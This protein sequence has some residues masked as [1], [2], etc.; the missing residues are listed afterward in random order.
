[1]PLPAPTDSQAYYPNRFL[2]D[3]AVRIAFPPPMCLSPAWI[4][5]IRYSHAFGKVQ[6]DPLTPLAI[7]EIRVFQCSATWD[8]KYIKPSG[9]TNAITWV[10]RP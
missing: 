1:M 9:V 6:S 7:V 3:L 2:I 8:T 5:A 4:L 10:R